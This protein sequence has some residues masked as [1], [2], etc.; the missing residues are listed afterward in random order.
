LSIESVFFSLRE[1][2]IETLETEQEGLT[3]GDM[4]SRQIAEEQDAKMLILDMRDVYLDYWGCCIFVKKAIEAFKGPGKTI[5]VCVNT[6]N[7]S[8]KEEMAWVFF[9]QTSTENGERQKA[10]IEVAL[11]VCKKAGIG[12]HI[13]C[14]DDPMSVELRSNADFILSGELE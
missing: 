1:H 6:L 12:F 8:R 7:F 3:A 13:Y 5:K 4:L 10:A 9:H 2:K 11:E 14:S